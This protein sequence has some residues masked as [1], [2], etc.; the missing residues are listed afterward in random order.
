MVEEL[1]QRL[2]NCEHLLVHEG[3]DLDAALGHAIGEFL[4]GDRIR[5]DDFAHNLLSSLR[6]AHRLQLLAL[7]FALQGG[8]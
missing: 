8:E 1:E 3:D 5:N 7:T 6:D 2:V 4:D